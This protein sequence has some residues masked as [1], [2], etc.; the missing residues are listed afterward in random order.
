MSGFFWG[1]I[2]LYWG[3]I[4]IMEKKMETA[5]MFVAERLSR[6]A[7][8]GEIQSATGASCLHNPWLYRGYLTMVQKAFFHKAQIAS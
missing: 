1:Y 6:G 2:R 5:T 3:Y 7:A 4:G 8:V